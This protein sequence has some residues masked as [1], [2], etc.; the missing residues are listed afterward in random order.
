M[1]AAVIGASSESIYAIKKAQEAGLY[2]VALDGNE[3]APGLKA[4]DES[5]VTDIRDNEAVASVLDRIK[6][7]MILPVPIGRYLITTGAMNDRYGLKGVSYRSADLCTDKY[8]FHNA[9]SDKGLRNISLY[10]LKAGDTSFDVS[11][12][13]FPLV[14]KPRY[15]SGSRGVEIFSDAASFKDGFMAHAPYDEDYVIESCVPGDEYGVDGIFLNGHFRLILLRKKDITPP[16][17]RQCI[18]YY[19]VPEA[20]AFKEHTVTMLQSAG[21]A[22]GLKD[23][24]MH[25]DIIRA[26][27][28]EP[29]IIELSPRPSGHNLHNLFTPM[30]SGE[31]EVACFIKYSMGAGYRSA[32]PVTAPMAIAYFDME[33]KVI[34]VPS[35][36]MLRSKYPLLSYC[37]N[38]KT[39]DELCGVTD[40]HS[41][42]GRGYYI[43]KA[44]NRDELLRYTK[45]L[46]AEFEVAR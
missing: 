38:I 41:L 42:M 28:D 25:A 5:H 26:S 7:D 33:G 4:A 43:L 31:D 45:A 20:G 9:L 12:K 39:G 23:C 36:E 27:G 10:L 17:Y 11:D 13:A 2:V 29:F 34:S 6:P 14:A 30:A 22:L 35:E 1:N 46:K 21:E 16:P 32:G 18:A 15:G 37:C 40:G 24:V 3:N 8:A 19:S 44:P